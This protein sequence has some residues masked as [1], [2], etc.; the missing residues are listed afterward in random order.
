MKKIFFDTEFTGLHQHTTLLSIGLV[1]ECGKTFYAELTDYDPEQVTP[2]IE[3]NVF[4]YFS[5]SDWDLQ[6]KADVTIAGETKRVVRALEAW[7]SQFEQ[8]QMWSDCLAYDWVLFNNLWGNA[9]NIPRKVHYIPMDLCTLFH[10]RGID[11]DINRE[12]FA[13]VEGS[14]HHALHDAKVIKACY[15]KL[16]MPDVVRISNDQ[17]IELRKGMLKLEIEQMEERIDQ[18]QKLEDEARECH[19]L[20]DDDAHREYWQIRYEEAKNTINE[21]EKDL[22]LLRLELERLN[23]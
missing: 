14:K 18:L 21:W 1:S 3:D 22:H 23:K 9:F 15:E 8:V 7:L 10:I 4:P 16:M 20:A 17:A 2:W 11:P 19:V 12:E 13:G 6:Q 5:K